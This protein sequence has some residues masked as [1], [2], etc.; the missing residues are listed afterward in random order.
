MI[1]IIISKYSFLISIAV[2]KMEKIV[3]I[4]WRIKLNNIHQWPIMG[5]KKVDAQEMAIMIC[6]LVSK[7]CMKSNWDNTFKAQPR[8]QNRID[9]Q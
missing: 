3:C 2:Y 8:E 9:A 7:Y 6:K 4:L 5:L 1:A